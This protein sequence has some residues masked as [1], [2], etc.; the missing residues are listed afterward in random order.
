LIDF[1]LG[2]TNG[3]LVLVVTRFGETPS[4]NDTLA[5]HDARPGR[6]ECD[7]AM[8]GTITPDT[9]DYRKLTSGAAVQ[10]IG[11]HY[12]GAIAEG[13]FDDHAIAY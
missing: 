6:I 12:G 8:Q 4:G 10:E 5:I 13:Q 7:V 1:P 9:C 2:V 11:A 3:Q